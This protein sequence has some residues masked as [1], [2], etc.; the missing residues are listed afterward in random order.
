MLANVLARMLASRLEVDHGL[1]L[2]LSHVL[3]D[4]HMERNAQ[5]AAA[6]ALHVRSA[7]AADFQLSAVLRTGGNAYA[8][9]RAVGAG[10]TIF[11][12]SAASETVMGTVMSTSAP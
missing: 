9:F 8:D 12:P 5:R 11:A 4:F 3:G 7:L 2:L 6:R 1:F 10:I